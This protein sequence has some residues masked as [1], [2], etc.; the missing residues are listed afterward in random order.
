VPSGAR[1]VI[2]CSFKGEA[3]TCGSRGRELANVAI[4]NSVFQE[5]VER[6]DN[7]T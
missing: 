2:F 4:S 7:M 6:V 3:I 5:V 1:M